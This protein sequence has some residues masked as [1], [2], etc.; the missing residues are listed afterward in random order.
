MK[1]TGIWILTLLLILGI[2]LVF[3]ACGNVKEGTI[4]DAVTIANVKTEIEKAFEGL[5]F[6]S[7]L[8]VNSE[9]GV[10]SFSVENATLICRRADGI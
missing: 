7:D 6:A 10:I 9:Q 4:N 8:T 5:S 3:T 1:R 2:V